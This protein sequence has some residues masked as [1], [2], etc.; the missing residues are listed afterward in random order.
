MD[1]LPVVV[2]PQ[3]NSAPEIDGKLDDPVWDKAKKVELSPFRLD[4]KPAYP[5]TAMMYLDNETL[6][7]AFV[8]AD[9]DPENLLAPERNRDAYET[10]NDDYVSV[11]LQPSVKKSPGHLEIILTPAN[12]IRDRV[13]GYGF[14]VGKWMSTK[15]MKSVTGLE[16][17]VPGLRTATAKTDAGWQAEM[18]IPLAG[19]H[20]NESWTS[21]RWDTSALFEKGRHENAFGLHIFRRRQARNGKTGGEDSKWPKSLSYSDQRPGKYARIPKPGSAKEYDRLTQSAVKSTTEEARVETREITVETEGPVVSVVRIRGV[22]HHKN[23]FGSPFTMRF[24]LYANRKDIRLFNTVTA[25]FKTYRARMRNVSLSLPCTLT[26][27]SNAGLTDKPDPVS[28]PLPLDA[29]QYRDDSYALFSNGTAKQVQ[30][31]LSGWVSTKGQVPVTAAI[32]DF[33]ELYPG[34]FRADENG[35]T[36]DFYS[37]HAQPFY[38]GTTGECRE[39]YGGFDNKPHDDAQ[40]VSR[41]HEV[42]LDFSGSNAQNYGK[43]VRRRLMPFAG[44]EWNTKTHAIGV[45]APYDRGLFPRLEDWTDYQLTWY[46]NEQKEEK[47]YGWGD[48]GNQMNSFTGRGVP[49]GHWKAYEIGYIRRGG[50]G[51]ASDRKSIG[52]CY[53]AQYFRSGRRVWFDFGEGAVRCS[54]DI[55]SSYPVLSD[56]KPWPAWVKNPECNSGKCNHLNEDKIEPFRKISFRAV[57]RPRR[58]AQLTWGSR[59]GSAAR[60]GGQPGWVLFY[61]L[62]GDG[63]AKDVIEM[64]DLQVTTKGK[65]CTWGGGM[66]TS[67]PHGTRAQERRFL[68]LR[69]TMTDDPLYMKLIDKF[70][71]MSYGSTL[72]DNTAII[73]S[74]YSWYVDPENVWMWQK[75]RE[76]PPK[77]APLIGKKSSGVAGMHVELGGWEAPSRYVQ[78]KGDPWLAQV[79][80]RLAGKKKGI[81]RKK[82]WG[83]VYSFGGMFFS[84]YTYPVQRAADMYLWTHDLAYLNELAGC[85]E[86]GHLEKAGYTKAVTLPA[87]PEKHMDRRELYKEMMK[88]E[89]RAGCVFPAE[90]LWPSNNYYMPFALFPMRNLKLTGHPMGNF[91]EFGVEPVIDSE[92]KPVKLEK[93]ETIKWT[94]VYTWNIKIK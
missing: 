68:M 25:G 86:Q 59:Y 90:Y 22:F 47:W 30:G 40:R 50:Y 55:C 63:R 81:G 31:R 51:W 34:G 61:F 8:C 87:Q 2:L 53:L 15:G 85:A 14:P 11:W 60:Q 29:M 16:F 23:G 93:Q 91:K 6:Y 4:N 17:N 83:T 70:H 78:L 36:V 32:R 52:L 43:A 27:S 9:P 76:A 64:R 28:V 65:S 89:F 1:Y 35:L 79:M 54:M 69:W 77:P 67:S 58:H 56:E 44:K 72:K 24:H 37:P 92:E 62:T 19:A 45:T 38:F 41:T 21:S 66:D 49:R 46:L 42:W 10:R 7:I 5:T 26:G 33:W 84:S 3:Q 18:A 39:S 20:L 94:P 82:G 73:V 88:Y 80:F 74:R 13:F 48:F 57:C 71:E 75:G 12:V